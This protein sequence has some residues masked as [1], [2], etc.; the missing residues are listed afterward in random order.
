MVFLCETPCPLWWILFW[1]LKTLTTE[2]TKVHK[3]KPQ[4]LR[5][6]WRGYSL[7]IAS[8]VWN[9]CELSVTSTKGREG[10]RLLTT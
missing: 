7:C 1:Q 9:S 10:L 4:R 5:E 8:M 2:D 3:G 6:D